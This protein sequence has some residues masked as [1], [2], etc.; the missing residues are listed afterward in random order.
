MPAIVLMEAV[1]EVDVEVDVVEAG[2]S[3][4][5]EHANRNAGPKRPRDRPEQAHWKRL[6]ATFLLA[7]KPRTIGLKLGRS[8]GGCSGVAVA[9]TEGG[10]ALVFAVAAVFFVLL[11][12][13]GGGIF[14][15]GTQIWAYR[16]RGI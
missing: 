8:R 4:P 11:L 3:R 10:G 13:A 15:T 2:Y 14:P 9:P 16:H 7:F 6:D 5:S 1:I 12:R